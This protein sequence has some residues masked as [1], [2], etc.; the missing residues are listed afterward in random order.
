MFGGGGGGGGDKEPRRGST[1]Q[2]RTS[3]PSPQTY[4][5][6]SFIPV[7]S[8]GRT[9]GLTPELLFAGSPGSVLA[10]WAPSCCMPIGRGYNLRGCY[11][12]R[13]LSKKPSHKGLGSRKQWGE[14]HHSPCTQYTTR[15][16]TS[17]NLTEKKKEK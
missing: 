2:G 6:C 16:I 5:N 10:A 9:A 1:I 3:V 8:D 7:R 17:R 13:C 4:L 11:P 12:S 15:L 14:W